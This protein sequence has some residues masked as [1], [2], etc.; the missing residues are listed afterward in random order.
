MY[1]QALQID[2]VTGYGS[3]TDFD[4]LDRILR[5]QIAGNYIRRGTMIISMIVEER[6]IFGNFM[7]LW[8]VD[9]RDKI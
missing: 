8:I 9:E 1:C 3:N 6:E 5:G 4:C 7:N 2:N